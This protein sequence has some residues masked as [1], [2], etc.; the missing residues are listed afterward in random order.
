MTD[1]NSVATH[2][3]RFKYQLGMPVMAV[4]PRC[5]GTG[6]RELPS[7]R[8]PVLQA[9]YEQAETAATDLERFRALIAQFKQQIR[10][11]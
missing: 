1:S 11:H 5:R 4:G 8:S 6:W 7:A 10:V 9:N 2:P 3:K